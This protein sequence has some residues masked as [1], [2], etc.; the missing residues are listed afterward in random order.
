[1]SASTLLR[2]CGLPLLI[3]LVSVLLSSPISAQPPV[4]NVYT[5]FSSA[6][7][8]LYTWDTNA[9]SIQNA[10]TGSGSFQRQGGNAGH[11]GVAYF[12]G[13]AVAPT[14]QTGTSLINLTVNAGDYL[15]LGVYPDSQG[16]LF[17]S[18]IGGSMSFEFWAKFAEFRPWSRLMDFGSCGGCDNLVMAQNGKDGDN[19]SP[20]F[21]FHS[22]NGGTPTAP[23]TVAGPGNVTD[24]DYGV[25]GPLRQDEWMHIVC[26]AAQ[27][28]AN[29]STSYLAADFSCYFNGQ[30]G[31]VNSFN[32]ANPPYYTGYTMPGSL[33]NTVVRNSLLL[34]ESNYNGG[35]Y[36]FNGWMDMFA[37]YNY[38]LPV[39]AIAAHSVVQRPPIFEF[40]AASDPHT[41][42]GVDTAATG[43]SWMAQ[44]PTEAASTFHKG[45]VQLSS[46]SSQWL[47]LATTSGANSIGQSFSKVIGDAQS[48]PYFGQQNGGNAVNS[49]GYTFE[50]TIKFSAPAGASSSKVFELGNGA[51]VQDVSLSLVTTSSTAG[52][53]TFNVYRSDMV[54]HQ[55]AHGCVRCSV[56]CVVPHRRR[57]RPRWRRPRHRHSLRQRRRSDGRHHPLP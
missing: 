24:A 10:P 38:P 20:H 37:F 23:N 30:P 8:V 48:Y 52:Q 2:V 50:V 15:N 39:E 19:N 13:G 33:P 36:N 14:Y 25:N 46:V 4:T 55:R 18:T 7:Q 51:N 49:S 28:F 45:V 42:S 27:R 9:A 34:G 53:V 29:D 11:Y 35:N 31:N 1:M 57:P 3:V 47:N 40:V 26:I 12:R 43:Y 5:T 56:R 6:P 32:Y 21:S 54:G 44:D 22:V 16:R 17:P 41:I